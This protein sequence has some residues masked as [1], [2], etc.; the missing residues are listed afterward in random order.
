[1]RD[2]TR[3]GVAYVV[4]RLAGH[5]SGAVFDHE[6]SSW[7]PIAGHVDY[8]AVRVYDYQRRAH[9]TGSRFRESLNLF[10]HADGVHVQLSTSGPGRYTGY[11]HGTDSRFE[12]RAHGRS[13][14][15]YD[16]QTRRLYCYSV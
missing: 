13:V 3:R 5:P 2:H 16:H 14:E 15:V 12:V 6:I 4:G 8:G 11:D 10:D 9:L 7:T 1:M